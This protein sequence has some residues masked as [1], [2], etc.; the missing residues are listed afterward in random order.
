MS[1][2]ITCKRILV[3]FCFL[4]STFGAALQAAAL[5]V[6]DKAPDFT[7]PSTTGEKISL[8]QFRGK[9][10]VLLEFYG[11]DY[12]PVW[13]A[14]LTARK[15]DYSKFNELNVQILGISSNNPFSQ[16]T[17]ADSLKLPY[18][19]LSDFP[20]LKIIRSYGGL[21]PQWDSTTAQR[22]FFLIDRQGIVRGK[23]PGKVDEVFPSEP[24]LKAAREL[25]KK[26]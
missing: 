20:D 12:S 5:E 19:L 17:F 8:S 24:I 9:K 22:Y 25:A 3:V 14:N 1:P 26:P 7:L 23:W 11:A 4:L 16:K 6:G 21:N 13:A 18:P 10:A 15:A 2:L